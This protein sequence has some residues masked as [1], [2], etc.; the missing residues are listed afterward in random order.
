VAPPILAVPLVRP[1]VNQFTT[2]VA[3]GKGKGWPKGWG[4]EWGTGPFNNWWGNGPFNR[5]IA[6]NNRLRGPGVRNED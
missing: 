6:F 3:K 5:P 2:I 4:K 1:V